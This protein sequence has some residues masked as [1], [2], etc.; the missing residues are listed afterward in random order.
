MTPDELDG[1]MWELQLRWERARAWAQS[2]VPAG[3]DIPKAESK[4]LEALMARIREIGE[5][6]AL[7]EFNRIIGYVPEDEA[8]KRERRQRQSGINTVEA[9]DS[10]REGLA[11]GRLKMA[12]EELKECEE[13]VERAFQHHDKGA[14]IYW[15]SLR[16]TL[17]ENLE[18]AETEDMKAKLRI[19]DSGDDD[20][21]EVEA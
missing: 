2:G 19:L 13:G 12:R 21:P 18:A 9:W 15:S 8:T 11:A 1:P 4:R 17:R 7:E 10:A 16:P 6:A 14:F 5:D 3:Q 20:Q